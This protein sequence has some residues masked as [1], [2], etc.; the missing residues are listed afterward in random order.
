MQSQI[1]EVVFLICLHLHCKFSQVAE[2]SGPPHMVAKCKITKQCSLN[3]K[4]I[5]HKHNNVCCLDKFAMFFEKE[6]KVCV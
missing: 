3:S 6:P 1:A 2:F 4:Y 5:V